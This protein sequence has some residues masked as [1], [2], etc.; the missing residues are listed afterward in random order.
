MAIGPSTSTAPYI[1]GYEPNVHFTSIAT[2]GDV[3]VCSLDD[4]RERA[5][6]L[7][8]ATGLDLLPT[9]TR[10]QMAHTLPGGRLAL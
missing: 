6:A 9:L 3:L 1:L 7:K 5:V 4:L 2:V 8:A 10:V